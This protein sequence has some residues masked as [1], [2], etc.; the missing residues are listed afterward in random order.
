M[1]MDEVCSEQELLGSFDVTGLSFCEKQ[2][3]FSCP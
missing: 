2:I 3:I 1:G